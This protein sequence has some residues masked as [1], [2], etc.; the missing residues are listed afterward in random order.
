MPEPQ[1]LLAFAATV[2]ALMLIPGRN[3][4][5]IVANSVAHGPR[6]GLLTVLGTTSA[7]VVQL[8]LTAFGMSALLRG[9]GEGFTWLRWIGVAYLLWLGVRQWRATPAE[10]G[11]VQAEPKRARAIWARAFLVSLTNPKTL[12]FYGAFLPQFVRP[13]PDLALQFAVLAASFLLIAI[14][15]D[16]LWAVAAGRARRLLIRHTRASNRVSGG[17]LIAAAAALAAARAR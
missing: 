1:V 6:Y 15:V 7:M 16:S 13:G 14:T 9:L 8:A 3:V 5:L 2:T 10:L 12:F 11:R 4:A 17:V